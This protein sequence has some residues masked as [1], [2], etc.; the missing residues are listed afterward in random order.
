VGQE[1]IVH[2]QPALQKWTIQA[3]RIT[4]GIRYPASINITY[5]SDHQVTELIGKITA[6]GNPTEQ[7]WVDVRAWAAECRIASTSELAA[8][9][10]A[11]WGGNPHA[12]ARV[13][14][15]AFMVGDRLN[16]GSLHDSGAHEDRTLDQVA[17]MVLSEKVL[18]SSDA[19]MATAAPEAVG[20]GLAARVAGSIRRKGF[21]PKHEVVDQDFATFE[22][23]INQVADQMQIETLAEHLESRGDINSLRVAKF[24]RSPQWWAMSSEE[25]A[26]SL[27]V[28]AATWRQNQSRAFAVLRDKF[29][30]A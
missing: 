9:L 2:N 24:L 15:L 30:P 13:E 14:I 10:D 12:Q 26:D 8:S 20:Q 21:E 18:V 11:V 4:T 17:T 23:C 16:R 19:R 25:V 5:L 27:G 29:A 6:I 7:Q 22:D 1:H 3:D 28:E